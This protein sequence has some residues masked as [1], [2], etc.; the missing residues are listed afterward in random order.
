MSAEPLV[1]VIIPTYN[2]A[3]VICK[4]IDDVFRQTY[5]NIEL[6][7]IDD[8]STDDTQATL[9]RYGSRIRL[10]TQ[11][12][13]GPAA[14]R[15]R[16]IEV[17]RGDIIAFQD[18][19]DFW[20]PNKLERQVQLLERA[21]DSVPCCLCNMHMKNL[22]GDGKD[23]YSFDVSL[24]R[25]RYEEGIWL[26]V[27]EVLAT[28]FIMFNQAA[29]IRRKPLE[30]LGGFD[31]SL[32]Y[33]DDYDLPMRLA[34]EGPWAYIKT[35]LA[36]W[37][38][39]G[40]DSFAR[41]AADDAIVLNDCRLRIFERA[42]AVAEERSDAKAEEHILRGISFCRKEAKA[43]QIR[44]SGSRFERIVEALRL[45]FRHYYFAALRRSPLFP[46]MDA[47]RVDGFQST[48]A[49]GRVAT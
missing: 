10:F 26:N 40:P 13:A 21:G 20:A 41:R 39:G 49:V 44:Q 45:G 29:A 12:N 33:Y 32:K 16:G 14:A 47:I 27:A 3:G 9:R 19:D 11:D 18:S 17:S 34:F 4:T 36:I 35:P 7:V 24:I 30:K 28:R 8:G 31:T 37:A 1:S 2:R 22:H 48:L 5:K 23:Y 46:K 38:G 6:I 15:N 25:P 42:L 43:I